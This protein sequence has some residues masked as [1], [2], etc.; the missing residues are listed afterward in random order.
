MKI[1]LSAYA[2]SP[3]RGSE[4]GVGWWW[5]CEI[6]RRGHEVHVL[7]HGHFRAAIEAG[8]AGGPGS[9][10]LRFVYYSLPRP[11]GWALRRRGGRRIYYDL[12]QWA[13]YRH[14]RKIH[15]AERFDL[16]HH[17]TFVS[18][19]IPSFMGRLGVPFVFGPIG[20]GETAPIRLRVGYGLRGWAVDFVR[21]LSNLWVK[22]N[23]F[24]RQAF[25]RASQ[26]IVTSEQTRGFL[27]RRYRAKAR[28][29][30]AIGCEART[31]L[32]PG[33]LAKR[34]HGANTK[35]LYIGKQLYW[36]GMHLGIEAFAAHAREFPAARLH[37]VGEGPEAGLW[38]RQVGRAGLDE[39]VEWTP[40]LAR[41]E[42]AGLFDRHDIL[43][44][45]SLHDSGGMVVLEAL[46]R[47][48][49]VICL[50]LGGPGRIV[51]ESC[52]RVIPTAGRSRAD[53]LAALAEALGSLAGD[54]KARRELSLGA[55]ERASE[56]RWENVVG[57]TYGEIEALKS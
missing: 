30:L 26:I 49:P 39:R 23:P 24:M 41:D 44:Y 47:G 19:R 35:I 8:G 9:A 51:D 22:V 3:G 13:A 42:L 54:D 43:L 29:Q 5:A 50:D 12:W 48:L 21:D 16:V 27:P 36:K 45:P 56:Y 1:L 18:L 53:V 20:G 37:F 46:S 32:K 15:R 31:I 33:D 7:T 14:V 55:L 2:C 28:V 52:G 17:I 57:R 4:P 11:I 40:W 6:A 10:K 34:S 38:R 25:A